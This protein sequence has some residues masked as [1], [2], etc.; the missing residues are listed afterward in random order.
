MRQTI[1]EM[2]NTIKVLESEKEVLNKDKISN[3]YEIKRYIELNEKLANDVKRNEN[4]VEEKENIICDLEAKVNSLK[5]KCESESIAKSETEK[6]LNE[7]LSKLSKEF[8]NYKVLQSKKESIVEFNKIGE[9]Y[10]ECY[11]TVNQQLSIIVE[12]EDT[13]VDLNC[14]LQSVR[15]AY[16]LEMKANNDMEKRLNDVIS[17]LKR[18]IVEIESLKECEIEKRLSEDLLNDI[19]EKEKCIRDLNEK[20]EKIESQWLEEMVKKDQ[21]I[22]DLDSA[23]RHYKWILINNRIKF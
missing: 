3:L 19:K 12:K 21:K 16:E 23:N 7:E 1:S 15:R 22:D 5:E 9:K 18:E 14:E 13:I 6:R 20:I 8:E 4:I 2:K 10:K 11:D 17:H